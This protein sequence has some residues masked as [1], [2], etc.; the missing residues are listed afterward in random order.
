MR[1]QGRSLMLCQDRVWKDLRAGGVDGK[2]KDGGSAESPESSV[3]HSSPLRGSTSGMREDAAE[4]CKATGRPLGSC[5]S[6]S[7]EVPGINW[8]IPQFN[9]AGNLLSLIR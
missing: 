8:V 1:S 5:P 6:S 7:P 4:A 9:S 3:P 2:A